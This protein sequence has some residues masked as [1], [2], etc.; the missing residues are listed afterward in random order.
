MLH[1]HLPFCNV[2][3]VFKTSNCLKNCYSFKDFVP[4]PLGSCKIYN[5][6]WGSCSTSYIG[7]TFR[8]MKVRVSEHQGVSPRTGKEITCLTATT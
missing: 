5:F 3:I 8:Y 2:K 6:T 1:N 7:K 4:E